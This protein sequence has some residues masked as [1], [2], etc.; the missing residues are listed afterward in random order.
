[1]NIK[2]TEHVNEINQS[3]KQNYEKRPKS[4]VTNVIIAVLQRKVHLN[5]S[6]KATHHLNQHSLKVA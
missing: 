5:I 4:I 6:V 2:H 3:V 1:M